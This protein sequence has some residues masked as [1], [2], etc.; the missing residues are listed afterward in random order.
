L[1]TV[2]PAAVPAPSFVAS[3]PR[4]GTSEAGG[5]VSVTFAGSAEATVLVTAGTVLVTA[6][7]LLVAAAGTVLVTDE[8][9]L[10]NVASVDVAVVTSEP[11]VDAARRAPPVAANAPASPRATSAAPSAHRPISLVRICPPQVELRPEEEDEHDL[12]ITN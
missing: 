5:R 12:R 8:T 11:L 6:P 9:V 4:S 3:L 2:H 10:V 7:T 1:I